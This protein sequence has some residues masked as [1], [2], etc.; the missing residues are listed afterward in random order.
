MLLSWNWVVQWLYEND[1]V[2]R[3]Y[4]L[5]DTGIKRH[6]VC[7]FQTFQKK[8]SNCVCVCVCLYKK[9]KVSGKM[10]TF[11]GSRWRVYKKSLLFLKPF[12]KS[13]I[14]SKIKNYFFG[15]ALVAQ[16]LRIH[17]P[18][19]GTWARSLVWE[20]PTCHGATKPMCHNYW[21]CALEPTSH[22]YWA[23]VPQLLKPT[24]LEPMPRNKR[25]LRNE[26]P[27]HNKEEQ[28]LLDTTRESSRTATKTQ[29]KI[30]K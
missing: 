6:H 8:R 23:R 30:N 14:I 28:P 18:M 7:N 9:R 20:D 25:R 17:L 2:F 4:T 27:A 24:C 29:R 3:K 22:N 13:E 19:Q 10:F 16:W 12:Y 26:K 21:A 5:E 11:G 1:L 15:T